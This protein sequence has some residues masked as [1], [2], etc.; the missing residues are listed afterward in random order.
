[1]GKIVRTMLAFEQQFAQIP[2]RIL[3]DDRLSYKARGVLGVLLSHR[4]G[5]ETRLADLE[6]GRDGREAVR[7]AVRE[8]QEVGYLTRTTA[9]C[10]RTGRVQ[11]QDWTLCDP[12]EPVDNS[13]DK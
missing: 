3:R 4:H 11:G 1:M 12:G 6:T 13:V 7:S 5:F 10:P 2:N 8:L 9:R